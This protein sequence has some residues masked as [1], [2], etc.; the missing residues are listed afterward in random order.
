MLE[1]FIYAKQKSLFEEK[2]NNGEVLDEAIVF[3]EDTKEIWNHGTYFATGKSAEEI[4]NIVAS[5]ET[6]Q[7]IMEQIAVDVINNSGKQDIIEDLDT[8]RSGAELGATALQPGNGDGTKFLADDGTYKEVTVPTKISELEDD[9]SIVTLNDSTPLVQNLAGDELIPIKQN[10]ENKA[11]SAADLVKG[12]K[13]L[14][15]I[16]PN[17]EGEFP[18]ILTKDYLNSGM[19]VI[20]A[21]GAYLTKS[22]TRT[23]IDMGATYYEDYY[24]VNPAFKSGEKAV[25]LIATYRPNK[26]D[27]PVSINVASEEN[28]IPLFYNGDGTKFLADNGEYKIPGEII[29]ILYSDLINL[30]N[31]SQLIPGQKYRITDYVTTVSQNG[32]TSLEHPFD[33]VVTALNQQDIS[34][35]ASA[36]QNESD[37]YFSTSDLSKWKLWYIPQVSTIT[38]IILDVSSLG[39][40]QSTITLQ[41]TDDPFIYNDIEYFAYKGSFQGIVVYVLSETAITSVDQSF[42]FVLINPSDGS[43]V[44]LSEDIFITSVDIINPPEKGK[45]IRMIDEYENDC[46]Y[47]FKNIK[48]DDYFTFAHPD[49][50]DVDLS[51]SGV[52]HHNTIM[53]FLDDVNTIPINIFKSTGS[54]YLNK[55]GF[56]GNN[57]IIE[58]SSGNLSDIYIGNNSCNN[59]IDGNYSAMPT[60][61]ISPSAT[62]SIYIGNNSCSNIISGNSIHVGN[63]SSNN[64]IDRS[65]CTKIGDNSNNN[66]L[67]LSSGTDL[68]NDCSDNKLF[69]SYRCVLIYSSKNNLSK[70]SDSCY[71]FS[72]DENI[73]KG[74]DNIFKNA[75]GNTVK[76]SNNIFESY[77]SSNVINGSCCTF[78]QYASSNKISQ[79]SDGSIP[80]HWI[81]NIIFDEGCSGN[82]LWNEEYDSE[83]SDKEDQYCNYEMKNIHITRGVKSSTIYIPSDALNSDCEIKIAKNS[84]GEIKIYCEADL[85]N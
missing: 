22:F 46:P 10:G 49:I 27:N 77:A 54:I 8:I 24:I 43:I 38:N 26:P 53:S 58:N 44:E 13:E 42:I 82:I 81:S 61:T 59:I 76:G 19:P 50:M 28:M 14:F 85:I 56:S 33:I 1:N 68:G 34:T 3:I 25:V 47:D 64:R 29:S 78:K 21:G 66:D 35:E 69:Y 23:V 48:F 62:T 4:E 83:E 41:N 16:T 7:D 17:S 45:I 52:A 63:N 36:M 57:N 30:K 84:K 55:I 75:S 11:V 18:T 5:S 12:A 60:Y 71:L 15:I 80:R 73:I 2:L 51:L 40:P 31:N 70:Y 9:I 39:N 20:N 79:V 37:T 32:V 72:S 74:S 67:D 65:I 6:V